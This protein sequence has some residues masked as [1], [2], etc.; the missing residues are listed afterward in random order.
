MRS[1][2]SASVCCRSWFRPCS[3]AASSRARAGSGVRNSSITSPASA[4]RPAAFNRGAIRNATCGAVGISPS[5]N[6]AASNSARKPGLRTSRSPSSPCLTRIRFSPVSGT[7]SATVP[8]ATSL[9]SDFSSR[10]RRASGHF[11]AFQQRPRQLER[12]PH[13]AK[14]LVRIR[15]TRLL[16]IQHRAGRRQLRFRQV[17]VRH[18]HV[19]AQL[20]GAFD[21]GRGADAGVHADDELHA[22]RRSLFHH[23]GLHAVAVAQPVRNPVGRR[24]SR[25]FDRLPKHQHRGCA[26]DVVIAV[27]KDRLAAL[28]RLPQAAHRKLHVLQQEGGIQIFEP[29]FQ[30][31]PGLLRSAV[32]PVDQHSRGRLM[33][34]HRGRQPLDFTLGFRGEDPAD[35]HSPSPGSLVAGEQIAGVIVL[36][37]LLVLV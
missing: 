22:V 11:I 1:S 36:I 30:K 3:R 12:H 16:R 6:P 34:L 20:V 24:A 25:R 26:V 33:Q 7:T 27:E 31:L 28:D 29:G 32:A 17:M 13:P 10:V 2:I 19:D 5:R 15:T 8:I 18:D 21:H 35:V 4:M 37:L 9:T 23:A 14:I